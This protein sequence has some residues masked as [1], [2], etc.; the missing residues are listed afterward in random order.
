MPW[1]WNKRTGCWAR[2][3]V[4]TVVLAVRVLVGPYSLSG[5]LGFG[6][7]DRV[8]GTLLES[9]A[10]GLAFGFTSGVATFGEGWLPVVDQGL[11]GFLD[12]FR[13]CR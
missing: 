10:V 4:S 1:P 3:L 5:P 8:W 7:P 6:L 9:F 12:M 13:D 2:S 11:G